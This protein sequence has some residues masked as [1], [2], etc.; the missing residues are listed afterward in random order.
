MGERR[1]S[2]VA[3]GAEIVSF[4]D[5]SARLRSARELR[6]EAAALCDAHGSNP[7]TDFLLLHGRRPDHNQA[8]SIGRLMGVQ[9]RAADGTL[10]PQRTKAEKA[11]ARLAKHR[12]Q[13]E[14]DYIDQILRLRCALANLA[15]NESDP[16]VVIRYM[17]PLFGDAAVIREHLGHAMR[18]LNQFAEELGR[19]QETRGGPG[20]V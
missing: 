10:Q 15:Q 3:A 9:V 17:D 20:Q 18:W 1:G 5:A 16:A 13:T 6:A 7:Y 2:C 11:A 19:E 4:G 8:A 14:D 12:H